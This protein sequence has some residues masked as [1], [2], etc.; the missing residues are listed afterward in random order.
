VCL[1]PAAFA[2]GVLYRER[3][4]T[5]SGGF[6]GCTNCGGGDAAFSC[7]NLP[8]WNGGVQKFTIYDVPNGYALTNVLVKIKGSYNCQS[9]SEAS[10]VNVTLN[11]QVVDTL[12]VSGANQCKCGSCDGEITF[13]NRFFQGGFPGFNN[14][15]TNILQIT[16]VNGNDICLSSA[17]LNMTFTIPQRKTAVAVASYNSTGSAWQNCQSP[18]VSGCFNLGQYTNSIASGCCWQFADLAFQDPVGNKGR[19]ISVDVEVFAGWSSSSYSKTAEVKVNDQLIEAKVVGTWGTTGSCQ[20]CQG[21]KLFETPQPF[22]FGY[23][24]YVSGGRN[25]VRVSMRSQYTVNPFVVG[26]AVVVVSYV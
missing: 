7:S 3:S 15:G 24:N 14:Y 4:F 5:F 8:S 25:V 11:G 18:R 12:T 10:L 20:F 26:Q 6:T 1:L 17:V 23:P 22:M 19:V 9:G 2:Q 13:T 21:S 16:P